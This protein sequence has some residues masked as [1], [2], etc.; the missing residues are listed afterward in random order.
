[1][2]FLEK[3]IVEPAESILICPAESI[4]IEGPSISSANV[5]PFP[6]A[7]LILFANISP[8]ALILPEAVMWPL[9]PS[10]LTLALLLPSA[11]ST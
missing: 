2:A 9:L 7:N 11:N 8:L 10:T 3:L 6:S 1:V 5:I 4:S